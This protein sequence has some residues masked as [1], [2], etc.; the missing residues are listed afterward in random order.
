MI[1]SDLDFMEKVTVE[2]FRVKGGDWVSAFSGAFAREG[3]NIGNSR[4]RGFARGRTD[5]DSLA[6]VET[7]AFASA[8]NDRSSASGNSNALF[9]IVPV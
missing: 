8:G 3:D 7:S 1:I 4:N 2:N 9:V 5:V 6:L